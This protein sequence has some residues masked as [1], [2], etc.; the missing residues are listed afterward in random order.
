MQTP[1]YHFFWNG[2]CSQWTIS[3]FVEFGIEFNCCE[4][5]MMAAKA[6]VFGDINS[7]E[8]I[9]ATDSPSKQKSLGRSVKNFVPEKWDELAMEYVT[10]GNYNKFTQHKPSIDFLK[11]HQ[12]VFFV[13]ASPF[14]KVWGVGM[15][16]DDPLIKDKANWKGEN[17]LGVCI[18][19]AN[20]LIK[21]AGD[22]HISSYRE[23]LDW[24]K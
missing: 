3:P 7:Y 4:Q 11:E 23:S 6:M 8:K 19:A 16:K 24:T 9:M 1:D 21:Q 22:M 2:P 15:T 13:E 5:F 14:D 17:K 18:N 10:L 20:V 12:D